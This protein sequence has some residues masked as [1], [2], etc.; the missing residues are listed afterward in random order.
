MNLRKWFTEEE[1]SVMADAAED[2]RASA[3]HEPRTVYGRIVAEADR[4]IEPVTIVRRTVLYG[5]CHYPDLQKEE[6]FQRMMEHLH[7]K[8]GRNGYLK[9]WFRDSENARQLERLR[10][11]MD[12]EEL[13]HEMFDDFYRKE[14]AASSLKA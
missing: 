9:L 5:L 3:G 4:C 13:M 14:R 6:H 10:N 11:M 2:H 7:E 8:Y 1:I 12:N